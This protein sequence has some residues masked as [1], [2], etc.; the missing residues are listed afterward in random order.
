MFGHLAQVVAACYPHVMVHARD[1]QF[2]GVADPTQGLLMAPDTNHSNDLAGGSHIGRAIRMDGSVVAQSV[3]SEVA[4]RV[5]ALRSRGIEPAL[6]VV[7][8]GDD[9]A[10]AVYVRAK[11]SLCAKLG[12]RSVA[13]DLPD[14][15]SEAQVIA[16]VQELSQDVSVHGILVQ[17]PLPAGMHTQAVLAALPPD[18]DVDGLHVVNAGKLVQ[19]IEGFRPCTPAG[20]M[21]MLLDYAVPLEGRHALVI[22]RSVLVGKPMAQLLLDANCTVTIAHSR[23]RDIA[24]LSRRADIVV[25]AAGRPELVRADWIKPGAAV[26]DVGIHRTPS[27]LCGDVHAASVGDVAGWLSPVPKG[28]GPMTVAMLMH[29]SVYAAERAAQSGESA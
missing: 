6:A 12:I 13:V 24:E 27:G 19:G 28:V 14:G 23:T 29:N 10:S 25:A 9:P 8:V 16:R 21:R 5:A 1:V 20:I 11:R 2:V 18:K 15:T 17:L 4:Q 26:V 3:H 22:G 7:L